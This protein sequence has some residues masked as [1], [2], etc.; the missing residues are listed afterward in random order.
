MA[1]KV[2]VNV[3]S[4]CKSKL[5]DLSS[6]F[7]SEA[8]K[9]TNANSLINSLTNKIASGFNALSSNVNKISAVMGSFLSELY[10]CD[11]T[12]SKSFSSIREYSIDDSNLP[13]K[14]KSTEAQAGN[15]FKT[16]LENGI[17]S[18]RAYK[19]AHG[20]ISY[21]ELAI[22]ILT[23]GSIYEKRLVYGYSDLEE[24]GFSDED[25]CKILLGED[26]ID[27]VIASI[28]DSEEKGA[29]EKLKVYQRYIKY[30][31]SA[32][33]ATNILSGKVSE[34]DIINKMYNSENDSDLYTIAALLCGL[35]ED[36]QAQIESKGIN[37][38]DDVLKEKIS[39][40]FY[41]IKYFR[42]TSYVTFEDVDKEKA[43]LKEMLGLYAAIRGIQTIGQNKQSFYNTDD[44]CKY[45]LGTVNYYGV[46]EDDENY[47]FFA[48]AVEAY[49]KNGDRALY[50]YAQKYREMLGLS[51]EDIANL[52][53]SRGSIGFGES[54]IQEI[55]AFDN[56][57]INVETY[58]KYTIDVLAK[59]D[60]D[61]KSKYDFDQ[62]V[63]EVCKAEAN[64]DELNYA[65]LSFLV[66]NFNDE[67]SLYTKHDD[68]DEG[69][70]ID[71]NGEVV[72]ASKTDLEKYLWFV[73]EN[74]D[75]IVQPESTKTRHRGYICIN[76]AIEDSNLA[77]IKEFCKG[78]YARY[79]TE[80]EKATFNYLMS[81]SPKDG[82]EY[83][84]SIIDALDWRWEDLQT[85]GDSDWAVKHAFKASLIS[86]VPDF[87]PVV[88]SVVD[89]VS[90][91]KLRFSRIHDTHGTY[92]GA[93][94]ADIHESSGFLG[95]V[96]DVGLSMLD[97]VPVIATGL[98][99]GGSAPILTGAAASIAT[100]TVSSTWMGSKVYTSTLNE[101]KKR[102][103]E[104]WKAM[105]YA[106]GCSAIE[107]LMETYS[108]GH[109]AHI[110][111]HLGDITKAAVKKAEGSKFKQKLIYFVAATLSQG[112]CEGEEEGSTAVVEMIFD[113]I[114]NGDMSKNN[115][116]Y[117]KYKTIYMNDGY[118]EEEAEGKAFWSVLGDDS[119]EVALSF[120]AGLTSG[121]FFGGFKSSVDISQAS[122]YV[123]H[124]TEI[125]MFNGDK[126]KAFTYVVENIEI[127][128][129]INDVTIK[130]YIMQQMAETGDDALKQQIIRN[131]IKAHI[132]NN[133]NLAYANSINA[134]NSNKN[135]S[136]INGL[137]AKES[138]GLNDSK[139]STIPKSK[140]SSKTEVDVQKEFN[141][142]LKV[143]KGE[144]ALPEGYVSISDYKT[145]VAR[146]LVESGEYDL[147]TGEQRGM[148]INDSDA[149]HE[150]VKSDKAKSIVASEVS[151]N[152]GF[153]SICWYL[154]QLNDNER[155]ELMSSDQVIKALGEADPTTLRNLITDSYNRGF[156][157]NGVN[158]LD[159]PA[160]R[161]TVLSK[162]SESLLK[163]V[164]SSSMF[165]IIEN[166]SNSEELF[167]QVIDKV[168]NTMSLDTFK[169]ING[170][171]LQNDT[172]KQTVDNYAEEYKSQL[173]DK[174]TNV[175]PNMNADGT[176]NSD[177]GFEISFV[178]D[179]KTCVKY[180]PSSNGTV[181]IFDAL[182]ELEID[183][184]LVDG[185]V[186]NIAISDA[187]VR[188]N[189]TI[190][191]DS[192]EYNAYYEVVYEIN[193]KR[194]NMFF[195]NGVVASAHDLNLTN[196]SIHVEDGKIISINKVLGKSDIEAGKL[197]KAKIATEEGTVEKYVKVG[198]ED[199]YNFANFAKV[200]KLADVV[201]ITLESAEGVDIEA[202]KSSKTL[203]LDND[204]LFT[205]EV[206]GGDQGVVER[207]VKNALAGN[208]SE[209]QLIK[210]TLF[211]NTIKK[212]FAEA[213]DEQVLAIASSFSKDG[214]GY[215][216]L[217]NAFMDFISKL[218]NGSELFKDIF[219]FDMSTVDSNGNTSYNIE[220]IALDMFLHTAVNFDGL[221]SINDVVTKAGGL[222]QKTYVEKVNEYFNSL[223][224]KVDVSTFTSRFDTTDNSR[225]GLLADS[226]NSKDGSYIIFDGTNFDLEMLDKGIYGS[227]SIDQALLNVKVD[228]NK[229]IGIGAHAVLVTDI[230]SDGNVY[231]SSWNG[232]YKLGKAENMHVNSI[233]FSLDSKLISEA[234]E[235]VIKARYNTYKEST[236]N[237][238]KSAQA[239]LA[240]IKNGYV[241]NEA[242][243]FELTNT[244][245]A[246][247]DAYRA[248]Y[249]IQQ[250]IKING[251][252]YY[253]DLVNL[254]KQMD[255]DEATGLEMIRGFDQNGLIETTN[256]IADITNY[257]FA[258]QL[259]MQITDVTQ[260][261]LLRN[262]M[263]KLLY[264]HGMDKAAGIYVDFFQNFREHAEKHVKAVADYA[265]LRAIEAGI[266]GNDLTVVEIAGLFHDLGMNGGKFKGA[267]GLYH[268]IDD[269]IRGD[270]NDPN[271]RFI[272]V[273]KT[274]GK[275][276]EH[277]KY[278]I[279]GVYVASAPVDN[280]VSLA[281]ANLARK[282]HPLNSAIEILTYGLSPEGTDN[283]LV[284]LLAMS[285]SKSTS[286][287]KDLGSKDQWI[288]AVNK[289]MKAVLS[290]DETIDTA[291]ISNHLINEIIED[292]VKFKTLKDQAL[293]IRDGDAMADPATDDNG[294]QIMQT[295]GLERIE[296]YRL[297]ND[298]ETP[299]A[300][301]PKDET[302]AMKDYHVDKDG[303]VIGEIKVKAS[304][305]IHA[306]EANTSWDT[307]YDGSNYT[308]TLTIVDGLLSPNCSI[309][310][311][312]ERLGEI[313]TY[314]NTDNRD[315]TI[316]IQNVSSDSELAQ[317][318]NKAIKEK[319]LAEM[320]SI[321]D[322]N[323]GNPGTYANGYS[324]FYNNIK[325]EFVK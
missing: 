133:V 282:N 313:V 298:Q 130:D 304:K 171:F 112:A 126:S 143:F 80:Q 192:L 203:G 312:F 159:I 324:D 67:G 295:G 33:D 102:G 68:M 279:D 66:N 237:Q 104:D 197:Y 52:E 219:G 31:Y 252:I 141:E 123:D 169:T 191:F 177:N 119:K 35:T 6:S 149:V 42:G 150:A 47:K 242:D 281:K 25:I 209:S 76:D 4:D 285:H 14:I 135:I 53:K 315:V 276:E 41:E 223:G 151:D 11:I 129:K 261:D 260:K 207:V 82:V 132:D 184:A 294:N 90:G 217:A 28:A 224:I 38:V 325:L 105:T 232:K 23:N 305:V 13:F 165:N 106:L 134:N 99:T 202:I 118:S 34:S 32:E 117:L 107:S 185:K 113:G 228:G 264:K 144:E 128:S 124:V 30:G 213:S 1:F 91:E 247:I 277:I 221:S 36:E 154:Y 19:Y 131:I 45:A 190:D 92:R 229:L 257:K 152:G 249:E 218:D 48:E 238:S 140:T 210:Y 24:L 161:E 316:V 29:L 231:V 62:N 310:A 314:S 166:S 269:I 293:A 59:A 274:T 216:A 57:H 239:I 54:L 301:N 195:K 299:F 55:K 51:D 81:N 319:S 170:Q 187:S 318:Y 127:L 137:N 116:S 211:E 323:V 101:A 253:D 39:K 18:D 122:S 199:A 234:D 21:E 73:N 5:G 186:S 306:G 296:H 7:S 205:K 70:Y 251:K 204:T 198:S 311:I 158:L 22:D 256:D 188:K 61:E 302:V 220:A 100:L 278:F 145:K 258:Q 189:L 157:N 200:N 254:I 121:I 178:V 160:V 46:D 98:L 95:F 125:G 9:F 233:K 49:K 58:R 3:F 283:S 60:F 153:L 183:R 108:A 83:L 109:L 175:A 226:Y 163:I 148:L 20:E 79:M 193:G 15:Y 255:V 136:G 225:V 322:T 147:L 63:N 287:I 89:K 194:F 262:R 2:D 10:N 180:I 56:E 44:L 86:L 288:A 26:T 309:D 87:K 174:L 266:T 244:D 196:D 120:A 72:K 201:D 43:R 139:D 74:G 78:D 97:S 93:V 284:A 12:Y 77:I 146:N 94:S 168:K 307:H 85:A 71:E 111:D 27:G 290:V 103:L 321:M 40:K 50:Y 17:R 115:Q 240:K 248:N 155:Q 181:N 208:A 64:S 235:A 138:I 16:L 292:P 272:V 320:N 243:V 268:N 110:E 236:V 96:Y 265:V 182:S 271:N 215:V 212:Y 176:V 241:P 291:S 142:T 280:S 179:G 303:N 275:E 250:T 273:D 222:N 162:D 245:Q 206:Y 8:S 286:G 164:G 69:Y 246:L 84:N 75:I 289:L 88:N 308:A 317:W 173:I 172:F 300:D 214:C 167:G 65:L 114:L 259:L 270:E 297:N 227:K 267:D 37:N 263:V 156:N 230:D